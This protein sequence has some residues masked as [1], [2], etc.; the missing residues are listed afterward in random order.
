M[1]LEQQ[2][3]ADITAALKEKREDAKSTLRLLLAVLQNK[4]IVKGK[5]LTDEEVL[6]A[7]ISEVKKRRESIAAFERGKRTKMAQKENTE[8][9]ILLK[10][11]PPQLSHEELKKIIKEA[12]EKSGATSVKE[13]GKV[14]GQIMPKIKGR[15]DTGMVGEMVKKLLS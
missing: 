1:A 7:V 8:L 13:M 10:Y 2:I 15:G 4:K 9:E 14:M 6:E 3:H 12:I 11:L 5:D